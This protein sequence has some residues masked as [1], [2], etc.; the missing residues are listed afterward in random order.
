MLGHRSRRVWATLGAAIW[1]FR[2]RTVAAIGLVV[3]AKLSAVTVPFALKRIIDELSVPNAAL[4][5][6]VLV[7]LAYAV[8]RLLGTV[9]NELRDVVFARVVQTTVADFLVRAF[10]HLHALGPRFHNQRQTGGL[11]R[12]VERGTAGIGFLLGVALFT[13]VPTLI[14]MIAVVVIMTLAYSNLFTVIIVATF[15]VY[16]VFTVTF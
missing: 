15:V 8:L 6:P 11:T 1:R 2:G 9:F 3:L 14:E 10:S 4:A 7:L 12:D 5:L 13:I 16:A